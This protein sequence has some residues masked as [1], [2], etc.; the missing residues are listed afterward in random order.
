MS[1]KSNP[2]YVR[3]PEPSTP[4]IG[5]STCHIVFESPTGPVDIDTAKTYTIEAAGVH[6]W[7]V[8]AI[9]AMLG[10]GNADAPFVTL[11]ETRDE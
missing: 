7:M 10:N 4:R 5:L 1:D 9:L 11:T 2:E 3:S 8:A 6:G